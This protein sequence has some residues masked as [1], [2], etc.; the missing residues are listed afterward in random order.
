MSVMIATRLERWDMG[1]LLEAHRIDG[2]SN[3]FQKRPK[4]PEA[5]P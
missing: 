3:P 5:K 1:T 2:S 4:A